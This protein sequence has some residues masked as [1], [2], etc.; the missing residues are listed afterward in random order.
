V[1]EAAVKKLTD[2]N[3]LVDVAKNGKH[4]DARIEAA[5]RLKDKS[6]A[7]E[8]YADIASTSVDSYSRENACEKLGGHIG[9][10]CYCERCGAKFPEFHKWE[11]TSSTYHDGYGTEYKYKC[12]WCGATKEE[13][14]Y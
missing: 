11:C 14:G 10:G 3:L 8:V 7:Q 1:R 9:F 5:D 2:Q 12:I 13:V 4:E 6:I